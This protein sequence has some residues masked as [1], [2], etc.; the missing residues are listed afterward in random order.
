MYLDEKEWKPVE[1]YIPDVIDNAYYVSIHGEICDGKKTYKP[2]YPKS[3]RPV[4][5]N[6]KI[7]P[8]MIDMVIE[9]LCDS[10][11]H[12]S[13]L[14]VYR[15]IDHELYPMITLYVVQDIKKRRKTYDRSTLYDLDT[16]VFAS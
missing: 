10:R 4:G 5:L 9:M 12:G 13:P 15:N 7:T 3:N 8:C 6:S 1:K 2:D 11:Y 16:I 14:E